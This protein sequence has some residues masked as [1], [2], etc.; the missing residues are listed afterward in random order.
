MNLKI[1]NSMK[2]INEK[3]TDNDT[4]ALQDM[5]IGITTIMTKWF[6][7]ELKI[8][9]PKPDDALVICARNGKLEFVQYLVQHGAKVKR[10]DSEC[11]QQAAANNHIEVVKYLLS[12]KSKADGNDSFGM[13]QAAR[14]GSYEMTK[15]LLDA[16]ADPNAKKGFALKMAKLY[17]LKEIVK[18]LKQYGAVEDVPPIVKDS[19]ANDVPNTEF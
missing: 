18:L 7:E 17:G 13:R 2:I 15:L 4:D 12:K 3:F 1:S 16:G 19:I 6:E 9:Q 11:L 5:G 8:K 14:N 10:N